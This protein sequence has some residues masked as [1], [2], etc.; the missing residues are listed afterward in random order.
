MS[1][2]IQISAYSLL[3]G[4]VAAG[5]V[6]YGCA[7]VDNVRA[8]KEN[9]ALRVADAEEGGTGESNENPASS[10]QEAEDAG[11]AVG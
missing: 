7:L 8:M 1:P 5:F 2:L 10:A 9:R 4:V 11:E 3:V 6:W